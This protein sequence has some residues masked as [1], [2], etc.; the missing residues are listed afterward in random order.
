DIVALLSSDIDGLYALYFPLAGDLYSNPEFAPVQQLLGTGEA[1]RLDYV[2]QDVD[3]T[4]LAVAGDAL[5]A[6]K[7]TNM[8]W[9]ALSLGLLLTTC[10]SSLILWMRNQSKRSKALVV[11]RTRDLQD[12]TNALSEA[13]EAL[14]KSEM[15]YRML[16]NNASDVIS[17]CDVKGICTY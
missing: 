1:N 5:K 12:R 2:N 16:A 10:I 4:S 15:L 13:N 14:G 8:R 11:E 9:W 7:I 3:Y 6:S 17:T